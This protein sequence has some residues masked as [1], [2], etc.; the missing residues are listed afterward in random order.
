MNNPADIDVELVDP[1]PTEGGQRDWQGVLDKCDARTLLFVSHFRDGRLGIL[2][3]RK[4]EFDAARF[5]VR[6]GDFPQDLVNQYSELL[7]QDVT[8]VISTHEFTRNGLTSKL[9]LRGHFVPNEVPAGGY[10]TGCFD[11]TTG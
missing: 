9:R 2:V 3:R 11:L 7:G 6:I 1:Q 4:G 8:F 10:E 5:F